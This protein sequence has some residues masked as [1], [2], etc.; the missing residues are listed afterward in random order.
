MEFL[1]ADIVRILTK[2]YEFYKECKNNS[3]KLYAVKK[4]K[5]DTGLGLKE[6]KEI[7]DYIFSEN[8]MLKFERIDK[9]KR[10]AKKPL[11]DNIIERL[12]S[13]TEDELNNILMNLD[14]DIL[15]DIDERISKD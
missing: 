4:L 2:D 9:L 10:L 14:V 12:K 8:N 5:D 15:M 11:I 13:M 7:I 1:N 6:S 3:T